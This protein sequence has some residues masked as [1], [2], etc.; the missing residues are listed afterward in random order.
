M[1]FNKQT[2]EFEFVDTLTCFCAGGG[3]KTGGGGNNDDRDNNRGMERGRTNQPAASAGPSN[4]SRGS[5]SNRDFNDDRAGRGAPTPPPPSP[6]PTPVAVAPTYPDGRNYGARNIGDLGTNQS[7]EDMESALA[8][9]SMQVREN[10][11]LLNEGAQSQPFIGTGPAL[12]PERVTDMAGT[13]FNTVTGEIIE[14]IGVNANTG[15]LGVSGMEDEYDPFTGT[16]Q[17]AMDVLNYNLDDQSGPSGRIRPF[18]GLTREQQADLESRNDF[19]AQ[20]I[21]AAQTA[22]PSGIPTTNLT[23]FYTRNNE[24]DGMVRGYSDFGPELPFLGQTQVY[25]GFGADPFT[26]LNGTE[27]DSGADLVPPQ[28]N[29]MTGQSQCPDGYIFDDDLQACR[30]KTRRESAGDANTGTP[31]SDMYYRRTALDTAPANTPAGFDFDAANKRFTQSYA[32]RP[33]FYNKPM[34]LTGFTKLL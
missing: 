22:Q 23:G 16:G 21:L 3:E 11:S 28:T 33:S 17:T 20:N 14:D 10:I 6:P 18:G 2:F 25:S 19:V 1:K 32:Y 8:D 26:A 12:P 30:M 24:S 31:S 9:L 4:P 34:D 29:P 15:L 13:T 5:Q 27:N 7:T